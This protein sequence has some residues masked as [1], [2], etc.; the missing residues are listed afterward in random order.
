MY[1][2]SIGKAILSMMPENEREECI[3]EELEAFTEYTIT[4][5]EQLKQELQLT[6]ERGYAFDNME[7]TFGVKCVGVPVLNRRGQVIAGISISTP[8]LRMGEEKVLEFV[9]VLK[10]NVKEMEKKL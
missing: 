1:C 8:S 7:G 5:R 9:K 3:S 6:K 10:K 2:T 4:N